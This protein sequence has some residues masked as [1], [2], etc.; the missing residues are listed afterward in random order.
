[1]ENEAATP[2]PTPE[3]T[4]TTRFLWVVQVTQGGIPAEPEVFHAEGAARHRFAE[5]AAG[6]DL[7]PSDEGIESSGGKDGAY[8]GSDD[9]EVRLW[10]VPLDAAW[11][12]PRDAERALEVGRI[13]GYFEALAKN[14]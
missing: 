10:V 1:M 14:D 12:A 8:L 9:D 13:V 11:I 4:P 7:D 3:P 5:H 6:M 2:P